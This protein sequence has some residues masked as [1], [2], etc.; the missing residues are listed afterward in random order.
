MIRILVVDDAIEHAQ[1]VTEFLRITGAWP[2]AEIRIAET[3][4][5]DVPF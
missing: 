3:Y 2:H 1:M 5:D 4:D